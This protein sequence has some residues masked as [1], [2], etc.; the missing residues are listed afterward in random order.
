MYFPFHYSPQQ[1][2]KS[3]KIV[4]TSFH[5][6]IAHSHSEYSIWYKF[7][8]LNSFK[9]GLS[10]ISPSP[11]YWHM[12]HANTHTH[13][14]TCSPFLIPLNTHR[15]VQENTPTLMASTPLTCLEERLGS[16]REIAIYQK[17]LVF[18]RFGFPRVSERK[19]DL[20]VG[21][22]I[23]RTKETLL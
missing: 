10:S 5:S 23:F 8:I 19:C 17:N 11:Y 20:I 9:I 3:I 12:T 16:V 22:G 14:H 2:V 18:W 21:K 15:E 13:T 7:K 6:W 4:I 1:Q